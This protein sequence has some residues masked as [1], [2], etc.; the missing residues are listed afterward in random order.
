MGKPEQTFWPTQ[1]EIIRVTLNHSY[2]L[3]KQSG[4]NSSGFPKLNNNDE[5]F[6]FSLN[7]KFIREK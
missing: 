4:V 2:T 7:V 3:T 5:L 1:I 6:S